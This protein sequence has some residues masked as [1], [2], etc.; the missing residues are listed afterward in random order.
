MRNLPEWPVAFFGCLLAGG[1]ATLLNA[2]WTGPELEYG[3]VDS[4]A[5]VAIVDRER[6]ERLSEHLH[7]CPELERVFVSR[8]G[9]EVAHPK[10]TKLEAVI[11]EV[12]AWQRLPDR[13]LPNVRSTR[14][15]TPRSS[16]RRARP[17]SR[18]APS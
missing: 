12:D 15:T 5:K 18:K 3:L 16:T 4:G 1:V 6:L 13:P 9:E 14:M 10:V 7:N 17:G 8:E 2:W 11:G